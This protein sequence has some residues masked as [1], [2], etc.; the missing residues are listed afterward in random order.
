MSLLEIMNADA[1][2]HRK[3]QTPNEERQTAR[4]SY[5]I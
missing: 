5:G 1:I 4:R 3:R 2:H